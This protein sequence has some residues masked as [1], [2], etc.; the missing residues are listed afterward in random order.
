MRVLFLTKQQY[1]AKDLLYDRFGRFYEIPKTMAQT[2]HQ[3]WGVC[4]KYWPKK[5]VQLMQRPCEYVQWSSFSLGRNWPL[6]F[7]KH[8]RRLCRI[9]AMFKPDVVVGASDSAHVIMASRLAQKFDVPYVVDLYDNFE[10][11][12][13]A[14]LPGINQLLR[15]AVRN[16]AA[17]SVVS[18]TLRMKVANDYQATGVLGVITNA[19]SPEIFHARDKLTAR[20]RLG[21][22]ETKILI[23]SAGSLFR[24][25]GIETLCSAFKI[26]A[27]SRN[28]ILLVLAGPTDRPMAFEPSEKIIYLGELEHE[29]VGDLFNALDVGVLCN[30]DDK[31]GQYCFPQ[32]L[33]EMLAC[34]LPVVAADVGVMRALLPGSG[35]YLFE[36][37]NAASLANVILAQL[38][39]RH[40]PEISLPSWK[41]CGLMFEKLL[42]VGVDAKTRSLRPIDVELS[43]GDL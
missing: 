31:F 11:Y 27:Q 19:I 35:R 40:I 38:E 6:G 37:E 20:R 4:L 25:R 3:V 24:R 32:K 21:L 22:P 26:I 15:S 33:F 39:T 8:Y 10:S 14:H 28:D 16:A 42:K 23:G 12:R 2:G 1:M 9:T 41:D 7:I 13:A 17:V 5:N 43:A 36:P 18:E 29:R 34:K 30:R